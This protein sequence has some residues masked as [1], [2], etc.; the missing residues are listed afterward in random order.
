MDIPKNNFN[1]PFRFTR[2]SHIVLTVRDLEA[3]RVFYTEVIGL[4]VT[5]QTSDTLYLRGIEEAC[6]HSVVLRQGPTPV[7]QRIGFRV[8]TEEDLDRAYVYFSEKGQPVKWVDVPRQGRTLHADDLFGTPLEI[9]AQMP[10][11]PRMLTKFHLHRGGRAQRIDHF[12]V[13]TPDVRLSTEFYMAMGFR[14][15]EYIGHDGPFDPIATFLN[16]KGNPHDLALFTGIGPRMHHFA[17]LATETSHILDA[18][19]VAGEL[20]WGAEVERGPGRHGPGH[21]LFVYFR[22]PDGHRVELFNS[23]YLV[24]D[25][26]NEP[27]RWD[28]TNRNV[29]FPWGMPARRQWF[30]QASNFESVNTL[31]PRIKRTPTTLE[32]YLAGST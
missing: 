17:Y 32:S 24:M 23:H 9:C 26:E 7:C 16:R 28:P 10:A 19:D 1:P 3:S 4:V 25:L 11:V 22:D 30:E 15:S 20:G 13:L 5:E 21:A 18:C 29:A 8:L 6:H 14:F 12:Q 2:T 27:V 31:E